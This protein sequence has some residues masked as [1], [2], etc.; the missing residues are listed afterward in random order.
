[1]DSFYS[2]FHKIGYFQVD[3]QHKIQLGALFQLMQEAAIHHANQAQIGTSIMEDKGESWILNR[4]AMQ[5]IRYPVLDEAITVRTWSTGLKHFKGF[6][7]FRI[8]AGDEQLG[9]ISTLWLYINLEN[10]SFARIPQE[11]EKAFPVHPEEVFFEDLDRLRLKKP[12]AEAKTTEVSLRY[13]D[14]DGN[15][16]VNNTAYMDILQTAL[17]HQNLDTQPLNLEIQFAKEIPPDAEVVNIHLEPTPEGTIFSLGAK[18][19][20][21]AFGRLQ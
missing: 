15:Q 7:E 11:I 3:H 10:K 20:S 17:H 19:E 5:M 14:I 6:R 16:H 12:G 13:T 1:M 4:I 9:K 2:L 8:L 21:A 18:D